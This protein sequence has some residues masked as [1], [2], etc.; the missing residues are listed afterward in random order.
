M[1]KNENKSQEEKG[2]MKHWC[3]HISAT[4]YPVNRFYQNQNISL[5]ISDSYCFRVTFVIMHDACMYKT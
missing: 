4:M 1:K 2:P 3:H 5:V